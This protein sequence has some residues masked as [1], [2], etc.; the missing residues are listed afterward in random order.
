MVEGQRESI[1][2]R[3]KKWGMDGK[4]ERYIREREIALRIK[5]EEV[6]MS[7]K[8]VGEKERERGRAGDRQTVKH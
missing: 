7:T 2:Q 5:G 6:K 1:G 8:R 3:R 4:T